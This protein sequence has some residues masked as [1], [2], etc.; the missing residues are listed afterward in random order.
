MS[1]KRALLV[2]FFCDMV[3]MKTDTEPGR[4][5]LIVILD[6][7]FGAKYKNEGYRERFT[8]NVFCRSLEMHY[9][10]LTSLLYRVN[11]LKPFV[12]VEATLVTIGMRA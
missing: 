12:A 10:H 2:N 8:T 6:A 9:F 7:K 5:A 11:V 1:R 4:R 3:G